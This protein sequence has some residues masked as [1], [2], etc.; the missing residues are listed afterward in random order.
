M[1]NTTICVL[2]GGSRLWAITL[3]KDLA[4]TADMSGTI[5]LYDIDFA[6]ARSNESVGTRIFAQAAGQG[7]ESSAGSAAPRFLVRAEERV[8]EALEGADFVIISIEP[9]RVEN[10]YV[11]LV[12]PEKYGI[13][14]TVGDT[15][16]PGG[17]FRA[18]RA[19]PIFREYA[20]LIVKTCPDAWVINYT[21]PMTW[22]TNAM[23]R[24]EPKI[25]I[26]GCCHEVFGTQ[27]FLASQVARWFGTSAPHH[28]QIELD[29]CGVNHFTFA[30]SASWDG[31]PLD[32]RLTGMAADPA[33]FSDRT[34]IALERRKKE[35]WFTSDSLVALDLLRTHGNLGAAGDRHLVE[36]VPWYLA[37]EEE[38][39]RLGVILTPYVWRLRDAK[40][41]REK[42]Y[43]GEELLPARSDEEGVAIMRALLGLE[44][45]YTN[46]NLPNRGQIP[47][48]PRG[49]VVET[50]AYIRENSVVP[51]STGTP[52]LSVQRMISNVVF[53]QELLLDG[54]F[55]GD[56][57]PVF[58]AFLHDALVRLPVSRARELFDQMERALVD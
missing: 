4:L 50:N 8:D 29:V 12:I 19:V 17:I 11:D 42:V 32:S 7:S 35:Q 48:L 30:L 16:G 55:A 14:Q 25:K 1:K 13:L 43:T 15:I 40:A 44:P 21:N 53:E 41:K 22:C 23:S 46:L 34:E 26:L 18:I 10:R 20:R 49:H 33:T 6:A 31:H 27:R 36:F 45:L 38:L 54:L 28:K 51:S 58:Q 2:G 52:A 39:H 5:R 3:M 9:G 56:T 57:Q 24:E 47:W 37:D